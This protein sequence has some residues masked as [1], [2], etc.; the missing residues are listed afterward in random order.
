MALTIE[1][2]DANA[3]LRTSPSPYEKNIIVEMSEDEED[4]VIG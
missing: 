2:L 1:M 4:A 3:E